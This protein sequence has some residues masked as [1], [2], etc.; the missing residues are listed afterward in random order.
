MEI[1]SQPRILIKIKRYALCKTSLLKLISY[2]KALSSLTH[3]DLASMTLYLTSWN[4]LLGEDLIIT[5]Q[6]SD[7]LVAG[8]QVQ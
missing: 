2:Q 5:F 1:D 8:C 6:V 7:P 4:I 3:W